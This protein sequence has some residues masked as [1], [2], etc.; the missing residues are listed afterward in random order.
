MT[1]DLPP[2]LPSAAL[3]RE[4]SDRRDVPTLVGREGVPPTRTSGCLAAPEL[5]GEP[6]H[7]ATDRQ[8]DRPGGEGREHRGWRR[9]LG[10]VGELGLF[11]E[12]AGAEARRAEM[13]DRLFRTGL[14]QLR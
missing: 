7:L 2:V 10:L 8:G 13:T 14:H 11:D 12:D 1:A 6:A 4:H 9:L 5:A 3:H